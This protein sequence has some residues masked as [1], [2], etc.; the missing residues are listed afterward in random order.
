MLKVS[1][2]LRKNSRALNNGI[3]QMIFV[4]GLN[5]SGEITKYTGS[6]AIKSIIASPSPVI[7]VARL[8][9]R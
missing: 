4:F 7:D 6:I 2:T 9:D 5:L 1:L 3:S 8:T